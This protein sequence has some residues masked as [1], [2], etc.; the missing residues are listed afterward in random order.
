MNVHVR[1]LLIV[2]ALLFIASFV[3]AQDG[4]PAFTVEKVIDAPVVTSIVW[5]PDGGM[6]F[7]QKD[8]LVRYI[9]PDGTPQE[10]PV[11]AL[12]VRT[13][14]EDGLL[15]MALDPD[16]ETNGYFYVYYTAAPRNDQLFNIM[17][18]YT[19][20]DG[21]GVDPERLLVYVVESRL[22]QHS[23]GR[24]RF[25]ENGY[26][27]LSIGDLSHWSKHGQNPD[28]LESR[29]HRFDLSSGELA[30]APGNP[31]EGNSTYAIGLRNVFS[32]VFD[33]LSGAIFATNNGPDC[34]D[35]V[36]RIAPGDNFGWGIADLASND[37][38][39]AWCADDTRRDGTT[40]A[41]VYYTPTIAP[42]G[43]MIYNGQ[44]FPEWQGD[45][46]FCSYKQLT[47]LHADLN[48]TRDALLAEPQPVST[49]DMPNC[50]VEIA[51]GADDY[52]YYSDLTAIYRIKPAES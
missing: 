10:E 43:I 47:M 6:F 2:F 4:Q 14:N 52:I 41:L 33:P 38:I 35:L 21:K 11:L 39:V 44:Y 46:F 51:Q 17:A 40:P 20:E 28:R 27:Y 9:S 45:L 8:G 37:D 50:A 12:N 22:Y 34:D 19:L 7:T 23:G 36:A 1:V 25:D 29:I 26:L 16:F 3:S 13:E 42:T 31:T 32:F 48:E 15:S 18:R 24:M 30:P 5:A 49:G